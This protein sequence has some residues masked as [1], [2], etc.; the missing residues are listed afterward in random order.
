LSRGVPVV[1]GQWSVVLPHNF[2]IMIKLE[3]PNHTFKIKQENDIEVIFDELRK[4][5]VRLTPEEWVRQNFVQYLIQVK[6]Y[7]PALIA[8][9]KEIWLNDLKK[10]FDMLVYN[11]Q[12]QPWML[13]ECKAMNV[14]INEKV[15]EQ[16]LRYNL[17]LPVQYLVITN[18]LFCHAAERKA[19]EL[20]YLKDCPVSAK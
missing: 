18:G 3:F 5:W 1:R 19:G 15:L 6:N 8:I 20:L 17:A 7:P 14:P 10:R 16:M 4:R 2:L 11:G 12:Y 13:I 9:E